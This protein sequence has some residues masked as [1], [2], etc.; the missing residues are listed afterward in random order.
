MANAENQGEL[1]P[2]NETPIEQTA[3]QVEAEIIE[4]YSIDKEANTELVEKMVADKIEDNKKFSTV[5]RQKI[6]WR[7]KAEAN[8]E[9]ATPVEPAKPADPAKPATP[10]AQPEGINANDL[11]QKMDEKFEERDLNE[12]DLS[13]ELKAKVKTYAKTEG[14]TIK[15]ALDSDYVTFIKQDSENQALAEDASLGGKGKAVTK[16]DYTTSQKF[17]GDLSTKEGKEEF[18]EWEKHMRT[19]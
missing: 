10:P 16:R 5:I 9:P 17:E 1:D 15:V 8:A 13:D 11:M 4:K 6:D 12:T 3:D 7:T 2:K 19:L 14:V 18:K